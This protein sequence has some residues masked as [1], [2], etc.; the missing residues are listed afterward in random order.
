MPRNDETT[1][2]TPVTKPGCC[3]PAGAAPCCGG[4]EDCGC[5]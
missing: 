4:V 1:C 5:R 2:C 3:P